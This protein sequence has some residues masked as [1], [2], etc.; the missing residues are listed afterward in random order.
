MVKPVFR[1]KTLSTKVT[2]EEY[3]Q[4]QGLAGDQTLSEWMRDVLLSQG[5]GAL[6]GA[7][8]GAAASG[9]GTRVLLAEV[10][11]LRTALLNLFYAL[12]R[13]ERITPEQVQGII[14]RADSDKLARAAEKLEKP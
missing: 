7:S 12:A 14:D 10:L 8:P 11:A 13:G 3:A 5:Q 1:T 4:L 2:D 6:A 9:A